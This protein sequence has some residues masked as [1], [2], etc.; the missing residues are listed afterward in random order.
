LKKQ[1]I[2]CDCGYTVSSPHGEEDLID[3]ASAHVK[4]V[5]P[6]M[7]MSKDQIRKMIKPA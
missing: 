3:S 4:R 7:S 1:M 5:H 6:A 2:A